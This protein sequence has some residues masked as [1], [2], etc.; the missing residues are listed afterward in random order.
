MNSIKYN[1]RILLFNLIIIVGLGFSACTEDNSAVVPKAVEEYLQEL[2]VIVSAEKAEVEGCVVGY[3]KGDFKVYEE[4]DYDTITNRYMDSL[5]VAEEIMAIP[6]VTIEEL[7]YANYAITAAGKAFNDSRFISDRRP[8]QEIIV[9]CD[10]LRSNTPVGTET[11]YAPPEADS[12]FGAAISQARSWRDLST[13]IDRQVAEETD[14][15]NQA[16]V[17]YENAIIK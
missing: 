5:L 11:G 4:S 15:L 9:E 13:T 14:S 10:T 3:N 2:S 8:L 17:V 1:S 12:A 7:A 16:L 6:N